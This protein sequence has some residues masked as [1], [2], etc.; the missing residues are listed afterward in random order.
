MKDFFQVNGYIFNKDT[1]FD[2]TKIK[3]FG[4]GKSIF[5]LMSERFEKQKN[6][7][8]VSHKDS[9]WRKFKSIIFKLCPKNRNL[10]NRYNMNI[11]F[12]DF[13]NTYRGLRHSKGLPV[14]GQRT[15][16]NAWSVYRS[17]LTLRKFKLD[18]SRRI[19]GNM[20]T[21][22]L[23]TI[24]LAEQINYIWKLQWKKE[25]RQARI[26]RL[27]LMQNDHSI[28]KI[29]LNAMS[30]GYLSGFETK[31]Q[32]TKKK[33]N[34]TGKNIFTLGFE[35]GFALY[36]LRPNTSISTKERE[37]IKIILNE[38]D[39]KLKV[40]QKKKKTIL[41]KKPEKKKKKTSWE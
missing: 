15:W 8:I 19:Y 10:L 7:N 30:K 21:N 16:T 4:W 33:K 26:K 18:I 39:T 23:N 14:R 38:D 12:L 5:K 24:Y 17:N 28:F 20:P 1:K 25:W 13:L 29:D 6:E 32:I 36:Y 41:K 40:V 31:K 11:F 35:P 34:Q 37:K 9:E 27:K 22:T 2:Q 3:I